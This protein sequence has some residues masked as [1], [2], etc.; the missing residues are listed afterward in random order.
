MMIIS[1]LSSQGKLDKAFQ[2]VNNAIIL[3]ETPRDDIFAMYGYLSLK[4]SP[5]NYLEALKSFDELVRRH[6]DDMNL[7][8]VADEYV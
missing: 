5:P 7:V 1:S 6:P 2:Q 4:S 8:R 3:Y